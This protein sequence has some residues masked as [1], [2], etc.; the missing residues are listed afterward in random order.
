MGPGGSFA[1]SEADHLP[2]ILRFLELYL[3]SPV[4]LQ[5]SCLINEA[6][7]YLSPPFYLKFAKPMNEVSDYLHNGIVFTLYFFKEFSAVRLSWINKF[8]CIDISQHFLKSHI[9]QLH[10]VDKIPPPCTGLG[11]P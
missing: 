1:G 11:C 6:Q 10:S 8:N 5:G 7:G 9:F 2:P 4:R 3:H